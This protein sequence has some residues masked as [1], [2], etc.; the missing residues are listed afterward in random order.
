[1][2]LSIWLAAEI[3]LRTERMV[4][5][6]LGWIVFE[7]VEDFVPGVGCDGEDRAGAAIVCGWV[8]RPERLAFEIRDFC[9][10]R[11]G[12]ERSS[13]DVPELRRGIDRA[14]EAA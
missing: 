14:D 12:N 10:S 2:L 9:P 7:G 4:G 13:R 1:M 5:R 8:N 11:F 3:G 6:D